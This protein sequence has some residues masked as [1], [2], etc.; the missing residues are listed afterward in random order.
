MAIFTTIESP[1][2]IFLSV[3]LALSVAAVRYRWSAIPVLG[4]VVNLYLI[5]GLGAANWIRFGIWCAIGLLVYALY[6]YHHSRRRS[7]SFSSS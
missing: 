7:E 5:A 1:Y 2:A 4:V 3:F 6:G